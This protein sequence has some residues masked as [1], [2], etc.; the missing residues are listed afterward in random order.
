[1]KKFLKITA[2]V[3]VTLLMLVLSYAYIG[4][5]TWSPGEVKATADPGSL[6]YYQNSYAECR[7]S[8]R[9]EAL[10]MKSRFDSVKVFPIQVNSKTDSDLTIDV[11]YIPAQNKKSKLLILSSGIH[12]VEGF[13]GSAVQQ[14]VMNELIT[15]DMVAETGILFIHAMNPYGFKNFRRV[16]ENNIDL[17]RNFETDTTLFSFKNE[18]YNELYGL[19][20]PDE[21][22]NSDNLKNKFFLLV[23]VQKLV[24]ESM[25][26]LR[27]AIMQ[28]QYEYESGLYFGGRKFEPQ[29]SII[30]PVILK[31]AN[32][33]DKIMDID[34][35]SGYG[36]LGVLHLFP[37]PVKDVK[38]KTA[39]EQVFAGYRIDWGDS[40]D[41]YTTYG[42]FSDYVG[43][44]LSTKFYMPMVFEFG[45]LN[46]QTTLGVVHSLQNMILENQ[47]FHQGYSSVKVKEEIS[48]NFKE[49]YCPS[50]P[51]WRSKAIADTRNMMG[52]VLRNF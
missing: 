30:A 9:Q 41:F 14:M 33:Y 35:H 29:I 37:D 21:K 32:S 26:S 7:S 13:V 8:F 5:N 1:M 6:K 34:L 31:Y 45:T 10:K 50:S 22:A 42:G 38:V 48:N 3:V 18:G 39:M 46:S 19:L 20:N 25:K 23:A 27:Q 15:K 44:L 40:D 11:C 24:K 43:K 47:G 49:M 4:Y 16:S 2:I 52:T 36:E 28:G 17:N 12:G 51:L